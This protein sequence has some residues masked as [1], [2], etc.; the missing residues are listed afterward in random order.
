MSEDQNEKII[1]KIRAILKKAEN[2]PNENEAA[3]AAAMASELMMRHNLTVEQIDIN[4]LENQK[5]EHDDLVIDCGK[6]FP[7]EHEFIGAILEKFYLVKLVYRIGTWSGK[8]SI[9]IYG[10]RH[11]AEIGFYVYKFLF[12]TYRDLFAKLRNRINSEG[13]FHHRQLEPYRNSYYQGLTAGIHAVLESQRESIKQEYGL[14]PV[15]PGLDDS[16]NGFDTKKAS[17]FEKETNKDLFL[18]G[19][20]HGAKIRISPAI[21]TESKTPLAIE[22]SA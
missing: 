10:R 15:D 21:E 9:F 8:R 1:N 17:A 12:K 11:N 19:A 13:V 22:A 4:K 14:V 3:T 5:Y 7:L 20:S 6:R 18:V 16:V 2:N